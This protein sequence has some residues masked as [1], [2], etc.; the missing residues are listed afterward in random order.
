MQSD[1]ETGDGMTA[2]SGCFRVKFRR[3]LIFI[4]SILMSAPGTAIALSQ[5][6]PDT[7]TRLEQLYSQAQEAQSRGD[8]RDAAEKYAEILKLRP[9]LAEVRANLGLMHHLLGEYAKAIQNFEAALRAKPQLFVP[10]LFFGLD[11]LRL[12]Q[13][14][15]ALTYLERAQR[16]NPKDVQPVLGL[17]QAYAELHEFKKANYWYGRACRSILGAPKPGTVKV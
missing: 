15:H 16:L 5:Q 7:D 10:N 9:D 8:Y 12:Q 13:P 4:I 17:G 6:A 3:V 1:E 2:S 11:L 14:Q